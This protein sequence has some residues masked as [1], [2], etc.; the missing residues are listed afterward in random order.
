[1][2]GRATAIP[3]VCYVSNLADFSATVNDRN[4]C[5][6]VLRDAPVLITPNRKVQKSR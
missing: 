3:R 4:R 1:M 5:I 2:S 6:L